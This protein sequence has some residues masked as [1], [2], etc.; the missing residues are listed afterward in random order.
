MIKI[1]SNE[2]LFSIVM[3]FFLQIFKLI[4]KKKYKFQVNRLSLLTQKD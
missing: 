4:L 3:L 1:Y 2:K